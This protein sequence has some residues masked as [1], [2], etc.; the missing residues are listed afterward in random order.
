MPDFKALANFVVVS[1][2]F[3]PVGPQPRNRAS[4]SNSASPRAIKLAHTPAVAEL[5]EVFLGLDCA[6]TPGPVG[7]QSSK[8]HL[9]ISVQIFLSD[10]GKKEFYLTGVS[11]KMRPGNQPRPPLKLV[12][13]VYSRT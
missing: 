8:G 12:G 10:L 1:S 2:G 6:F 11:S 4:G 9:L 5:G 7:S 13:R 3:L